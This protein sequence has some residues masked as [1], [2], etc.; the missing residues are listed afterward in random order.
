M[1]RRFYRDES[2][3][4]FRNTSSAAEL[5]KMSTFSQASCEQRSQTL[6]LKKQFADRERPREA[7]L[8]AQ[9]I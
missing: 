1:S 7:E 9:K 3:N 8:A 4:A 2:R 5:N 6:F